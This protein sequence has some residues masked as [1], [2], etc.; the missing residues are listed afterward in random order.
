MK[1]GTELHLLDIVAGWANVLPKSLSVAPEGD[2]QFWVRASDV[3][4]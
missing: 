4:L 1:L 2:N 3:G